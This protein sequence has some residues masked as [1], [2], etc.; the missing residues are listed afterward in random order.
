MGRKLERP[1][2]RTLQYLGNSSQG[3][4]GYIQ[5]VSAPLGYNPSVMKYK[6][7][8]VE[9][10]ETIQTMWWEKRSMRDI[11][12]VLG[13]SHTSVSREM[14]R[15]FPSRQK[16][17]TPRLAEERAKENTHKRGRKERLKSL[18]VRSYVISHLKRRWSPEQISLRIKIDLGETI[19]HEAIYQYIY[20]QV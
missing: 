16:R 8:S 20:H 18:E 17:Y 14:R 4:W 13:R 12:K 7:F 5:P 15:N 19:S 6:H 1:T 10:R 9:E 11:A 3:T 2:V